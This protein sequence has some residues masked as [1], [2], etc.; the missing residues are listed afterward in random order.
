VLLVYVVV[1]LV[2]VVVLLVRMVMFIVE[3][4]L[5]VLLEMVGVGDNSLVVSGCVT[6]VTTSGV[7]SLL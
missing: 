7:P 4:V 1:L 5:V 6:A 2:Y 3:L